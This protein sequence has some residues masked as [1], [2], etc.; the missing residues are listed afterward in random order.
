MGSLSFFSYSL[1]LSLPL[2]LSI[3]LSLY[4]SPSLPTL[5]SPSIFLPFHYSCSLVHLDCIHQKAS[6]VSLSTPACFALLH[7]TVSSSSH[8]IGCTHQTCRHQIPTP[9]IQQ[10]LTHEFDLFLITSALTWPK[11]S[12]NACLTLKLLDWCLL[13][14]YDHRAKW[15]SSSKMQSDFGCSWKALG[16][17]LAASSLSPR[18]LST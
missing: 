15:T 1:S 13:D 4:F 14:E 18:G 8:H 5:H 10:N 9:Q 7:H 17:E 12:I 16:S 3:S 6:V 11:L 2:S